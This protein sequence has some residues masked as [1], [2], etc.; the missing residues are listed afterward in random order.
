MSIFQGQHIHSEDMKI[1]LR[2]C[3]I[4]YPLK[5]AAIVDMNQASN[6]YQ[7]KKPV[8]KTFVELGELLE[9]L[10][11]TPKL[12]PLPHD[13]NKTDKQL[14][15][16]GRETWIRK[17]DEKHE[18]LRE[19]LKPEIIEQYLFFDGIREIVKSLCGS[20]TWNVPSAYYKSINQYIAYGCV[21]NSLLPFS[22]RNVG[23]NYLH[24]KDNDC[25]NPKRGRGGKNNESSRSKSMGI[26]LAIK[27]QIASVCMYVKKKK[28][29]RINIT[30]LFNLY[31]DRYQVNEI[32]GP[33]GQTIRIPKPEN[34]G[35]T[36]QQFR[37]HFRIAIDD[38]TFLRLAHG[39][40]SYDKDFAPRSGVAR[41]GVIGPSHRYEID[42]TVLDIYVRYPYDNSGRSSMG[43]PVVYFVI[44]V[45]STAIVGMYI[46]FT[47]PNW[48]G[49]AEAL[50]NAFSNKVEFC[51]RYGIQI[52][53]DDWCCSHICIQIA[54]DNGVDYPEA[55][56]AQLIK[57]TIGIETMMLLALF[58]G[59]AK[60][61]CERKF[62]TVTEDVIDNE[63]GAVQ[64]VPRREDNHPSNESL[65]DLES[66]TKVLIEE[67]IYHNK[68]S[69]R[70]KL[71]NFDMASNGVGITPLAIYKYAITRE[72]NGGRKTTAKDLADARWALLR[73]HTAT[74]D[75]E[76]ASIK[77]DGLHYDAD[78]AHQKRW[79]HL[80]VH[81]GNFKILVRKTKACTNSI[82]HMTEEG[83][84]IELSLKSDY[85]SERFANQHWDAAQ[86]RVEEYKDESHELALEREKNRVARDAAIDACRN[87][88]LNAISET[89]QK[90]RKSIKSKAIK[91]N[92]EI[93]KAIEDQQLAER[94]ASALNLGQ[95]PSVSVT[96][97]TNYNNF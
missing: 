52:S 23:S 12:Y 30:N 11:C 16:E 66:L 49:A 13:I 14:I 33:I 93:Q 15:L 34:E 29:K 78:Y 10:N 2:V 20:G 82:W 51:S 5:T 8:L 43:R 56:R 90:P 59:D 6:S 48:E 64:K 71:H 91:T 36:Y 24:V 73:E 1:N 72:M 80:A 85:Q 25:E 19:L 9:K 70:L 37:Y 75:A 94:Y 50:I 38:E 76:S 55:N 42:S 96:E 40:L 89:Q 54:M 21:K 18:N 53:E 95:K 60:G 69:E 7:L 28:Y 26:T 92:K 67:I 41:D 3:A 84:I 44:D 57:S 47:G 65:W 74:V 63:S 87:D 58:R 83:E 81:R 35:I 31:K 17:R 22:L 45:Y 68:S 79:Y 27:I 32:V 4:S 62:K 88:Q 86:I 61:I 77:L 97:N 39:D 46:G